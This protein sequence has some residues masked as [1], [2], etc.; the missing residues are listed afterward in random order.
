MRSE[1]LQAGML[2]SMSEMGVTSLNFHGPR[3]LQ[4]VLDKMAGFYRPDM[5]FTV[6][7]YGEALGEALPP[8]PRYN[9]ANMS[10]Q[11]IPVLRETSS[12]PKI[13]PSDVVTASSSLRLAKK[14]RTDPGPGSMGMSMPGQV[15]GRDS[16]PYALCY[17]CKLTDFPGKFQPERAKALGLT[18]GPL[19]A[20]IQKLGKIVVLPNGT[21][22]KPSD[23]MTPAQP[24]PVVLVVDCPSEQYLSSLV[25]N[26][27][28]Q[29]F[30]SVNS[31]SSGQYLCI[32][33]LSPAHVVC[34]EQY[35]S[36]MKSF[37]SDAQHLMMHPTTCVPREAFVSAAAQQCR[38]NALCPDFFPSLQHSFTPNSG[39][40]SFPAF[41]DV[42]KYS[43]GDALLKL[44]L[45]PLGKAGVFDSS[46]V[47]KRPAYQK[48]KKD[49]EGNEYLQRSAAEMRTRMAAVNTPSPTNSPSRSQSPSLRGRER[50]PRCLEGISRDQAEL[51]FLGTGSAIPAAQRN[52][53]G[54]Y[55]NL[56]GNGGMLMDCG[57]GTYGQLLSLYGQTRVN[58]ILASLKCIWLSHIH[59]DHHAGVLKVLHAR[60]QLRLLKEGEG[61]AQGREV[62][63]EPVVVI[64]PPAVNSWLDICSQAE[65]TP[66]HFD[67]VDMTDINA[68]RRLG[69]WA[70]AAL[71]LTQFVQVPVI[72]CSRSYG[73]VIEHQCGWKL[74][75]SGDTRP[76]ERLIQEGMGATVLIHEATFDDSLQQEAIDKRHSTV[77]EALHVAK[78]MQAYRTVLTHFS[79]RYPSLPV[80]GDT[81]HTS[82]CV[83][84]DFMSINFADLP[85]VPLCLPLLSALFEPTQSHRNNLLPSDLFTAVSPTLQYDV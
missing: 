64:G 11:P 51:V 14:A 52:V 71:G 24:G 61:D 54:I 10:V 49:I 47:V 50:V 53:S 41:P 34:T 83:A 46:E 12:H 69:E 84:L 74:V 72:H 6:N 4:S 31:A 77:K 9:D 82:V 68:T 42:G 73:L 1:D 21:Q 2:L 79:Q 37:G 23:V 28:F 70:E 67:F 20:E 19:Y 75:Y 60:Q 22:I 36:W 32:V 17:I 78:R 35:S 40:G 5:R 56:F 39:T 16:Q 26:A 30:M 66:L 62:E 18:P 8:A 55:L 85:V 58:E 3:M 7:E 45:R 13:E 81:T 76:C 44:H 33:H 27:A 15:P 59:A 80:V 25:C 43:Q 29:P 65:S 63:M 57:E 38:L 48:I